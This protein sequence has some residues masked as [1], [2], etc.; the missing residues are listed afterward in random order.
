MLLR[1]SS[2][3]L[4]SYASFACAAEH[5]KVGGGGAR[6]VGGA[7]TGHD[8]P[9]V[10]R[11]GPYGGAGP[12]CEGCQEEG[13]ARAWWG[14]ADLCR[15]CAAGRNGT[16]ASLALV[17]EVVGGGGSGGGG[18]KVCGGGGHGGYSDSGRAADA[19]YRRM[20]HADP[21][22]SL[23]LG[24]YARFLKDVEGDVARAQESCERAIVA[25]P[26]DGGALALYAG[27]V[28]ETSRDADRADAYY[29]PRRPGRAR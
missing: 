9:R 8:V 12:D 2:S 20:I 19:Y 15:L 24:N 27:L 13:R 10:V 29:N 11:G 18:K 26:G 17:E 1:S 22:N 25:N 16:A 21:V 23:L 3:P 5:G 4:L 28:W 6:V 7:D 14:D